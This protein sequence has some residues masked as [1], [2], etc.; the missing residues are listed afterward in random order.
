MGKENVPQKLPEKKSKVRIIVIFFFALART[1]DL[2]PTV[3]SLKNTSKATAKKAPFLS[4]A[5]RLFS[6]FAPN[7]VSETGVL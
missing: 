2:G 4:K 5:L 6:F 3:L 1:N 7:E